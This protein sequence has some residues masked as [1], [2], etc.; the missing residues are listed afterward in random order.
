MEFSVLLVQATAAPAIVG[1]VRCFVKGDV[2]ADGNTRGV[3]DIRADTTGRD[4][5]LLRFLRLG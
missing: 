1:G 4:G 3:L 2:R 5:Q